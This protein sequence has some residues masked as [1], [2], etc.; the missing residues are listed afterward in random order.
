MIKNFFRESYSSNFL[1]IDLL[2]PRVQVES[3]PLNGDLDHDPLVSYDPK[4]VG[5][6]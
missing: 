4:T 5:Q 2:A 3:L 1:V 6:S